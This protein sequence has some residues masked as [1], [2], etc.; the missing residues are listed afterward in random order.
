MVSPNGVVLA[1]F[2]VKKHLEIR[3]RGRQIG[4]VAFDAS[5]E[6]PMLHEALE[7]YHLTKEGR[8]V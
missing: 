3:R 8:S 7:N 4:R 2:R 6:I 5:E 1:A